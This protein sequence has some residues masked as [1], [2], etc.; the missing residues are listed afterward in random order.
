METK[1]ISQWAAFLSITMITFMWFIS[2]IFGV[3]LDTTYFIVFLLQLLL[4]LLYCWHKNKTVFNL[5]LF[6]TLFSFIYGLI[7]ILPLDLPLDIPLLYHLIILLLYFIIVLSISSLRVA[8]SYLY[9]GRLDR[10]SIAF[11]F[12]T[13]LVSTS[14]LLIWYYAFHPDISDLQ[15]MLRDHSLSI[16]VLMGIGFSF[17]NAI[18]EEIIWRGIIW[19]GLGEI[20]NRGW[21]IIL[22]QGIGF[23]LWHINGF[24]RGW[25]G[26]IMAASYGIMLGIIRHRTKGIVYP[27]L[28]HIVADAV[29]FFILAFSIMNN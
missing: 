10:F 2:N 19:D 18:T 14:G 26:V 23:G 8:Q 5:T 9:I 24:P 6:G 22:L 3:S 11:M 27:I 25:L 15:D 20:F 1:N 17:F 13:I 12:G 28:T 7:Q 4:T 21:V 16:L 29:I